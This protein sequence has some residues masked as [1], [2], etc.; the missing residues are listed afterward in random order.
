MGHSHA[1]LGALGW[2]ALAPA[3]AS[4]GVFTLTPA[5][6]ATGV[7]ISAGA[8]LVPDLDHPQAT[9]SRTL[10]PITGA[11]AHLTAT[12]ARGH[13]KGT[14]TI[15]FCVIT[16]LGMFTILQWGGTVGVGLTVFFMSA[17]A[18]KALH[19]GPRSGLSGVLFSSAF[20]AAVTF[21]TFWFV[22]DDSWQWLT[23]AVTLGVFFHLVGDT[24]T[25]GG[26]PYLY[27]LTAK[28]FSIPLMKTGSTI[29]TKITVPIMLVLLAFISFQ[30][31]TSQKVL[32]FPIM[33][34][35]ITVQTKAPV[36]NTPVKVKKHS[37]SSTKT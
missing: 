27:P 37:S 26:V 23:A 9:V 3:I 4:T 7:F 33:T 30:A 17:L 24:L 18:V 2:A 13:R 31:V 8:A 36:K 29:E 20:A 25:V 19:L 12:I 35:T 14:H 10:G 28:R 6:Y 32:S 15:L 34:D 22:G 1:I 5:T 21:G 16:F 11:L